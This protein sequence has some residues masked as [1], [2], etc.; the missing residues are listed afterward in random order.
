[1]GTGDSTSWFYIKIKSNLIGL[2]DCSADCSATLRVIM[3]K[4]YMTVHMVWRNRNYINSHVG[5][6]N[7]FRL[8]MI[9]PKICFGRT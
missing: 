1:V 5:N 8:Y 2:A 3:E 6:K 9:G 7:M 4:M